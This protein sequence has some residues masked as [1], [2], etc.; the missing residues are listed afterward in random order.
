MFLENKE[1]LAKEGL[2]LFMFSHTKSSTNN[3]PR[4]NTLVTK[5]YYS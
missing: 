1:G 2:A 3:L 4:Q 5:P